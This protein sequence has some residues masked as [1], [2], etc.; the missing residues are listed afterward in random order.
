MSESKQTITQLSR[1][2]I[3]WQYTRR[4]GAKHTSEVARSFDASFRIEHGGDIWRAIFAARF[5]DGAAL[6]RS[7]TVCL[8]ANAPAPL[9]SR[10]ST[11]AYLRACPAPARKY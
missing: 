9:L 6:C 10:Q 5:M 11:L 4:A 7:N 8:W 3:I 1:W 2:P